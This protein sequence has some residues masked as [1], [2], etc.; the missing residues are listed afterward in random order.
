MR[1]TILTPLLLLFVI[2]LSACTGL[3]T[4]VTIVVTATPEATSA[5]NPPTQPAGPTTAATSSGA[6]GPS[7]PAGC[8]VVS[9]QP[10]AGP[11][12]QSLFPPVQPTDWVRGPET[13]SVTIMD[14]SDFQ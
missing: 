9:P 5:A 6:I 3:A 2:G 14:Y 12:E 4:P 13:A 10:T 7:A 11:T 1:K 8:T